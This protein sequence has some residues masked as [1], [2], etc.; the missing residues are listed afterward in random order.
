MNK[1]KKTGADMSASKQKRL[2]REKKNRQVKR[3]DLLTKVIMI[4]VV[5]VILGGIGYA[6]GSNVYQKVNTVTV[7]YT[8]LRA[9]ET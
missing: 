6:V 8:H 2:D 9:H 1:E 3:N 5:V 4:A 7:S